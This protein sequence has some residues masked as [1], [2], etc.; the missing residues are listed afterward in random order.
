MAL[1]KFQLN[2]LATFIY[3]NFQVEDKKLLQHTIDD[4]LKDDCLLLDKNLLENRLYS[5]D[6]ID[7]LM[8]S[9]GKIK[10]PTFQHG[11]ENKHKEDWKKFLEEMR[12]DEVLC[13]YEIFHLTDRSET[14]RDIF[15]NYDKKNSGYKAM[16]IY[17]KTKNDFIYIIRG[18]NGDLQWLD[19][20][21]SISSFITKVENEGLEDFNNCYK[22]I[23]SFAPTI[24]FTG[25][26]KGGLTAMVISEKIELKS[27]VSTLFAPFINTKFLESLL[28]IKTGEL[29]ESKER[30]NK[31]MD[32]FYPI[33]I[34]VADIV[35]SLFLE[36]ELLSLYKN[37]F[38][39]VGDFDSNGWNFLKN[40]EPIPQVQRH[41]Y[42]EVGNPNKATDPEDFILFMVTLNKEVLKNENKV[43]Y[44]L[45]IATF[46]EMGI[47][48]NHSPQ[49]FYDNNLLLRKSYEEQFREQ[50]GAMEFSFDTMKN[51]MVQWEKS[52]QLIYDIFVSKEIFTS[53]DKLLKDEECCI[54]GNHFCF[55]K[56]QII[57]K[58]VEE[59]VEH[60][61]K[62]NFIKDK[63]VIIEILVDI[64]G[65]FF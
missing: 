32:K 1:T 50:S 54:L 43:V 29:W 7:E 20:C 36:K 40:H 3:L 64:L 55:N 2:Q 30:L 52:C 56:K 5:E 37:K 17:N 24:T 31:F 8:N 25:H 47:L 15:I 58:F 46:K 13:S 33:E 45:L 11:Y 48:G 6:V 53:L 44:P 41:N 19:N 26:S 12:K 49:G 27:K 10:Y 16:G 38:V 23:S 22:K 61:H 28:E 57:M 59:I 42:D 60:S 65:A 51:N 35:G 62:S 14:Y 39:F 34:H 21:K 9:L 63:M 4:L 18:T